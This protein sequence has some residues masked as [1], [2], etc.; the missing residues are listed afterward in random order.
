MSL[1]KPYPMSRS[2][3]TKADREIWARVAKRLGREAEPNSRVG[4][5]NDYYRMKGWSRGW[6]RET[7]AGVEPGQS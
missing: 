4:A 2:R 1:R 3:Q 6:E 7:R 5:I